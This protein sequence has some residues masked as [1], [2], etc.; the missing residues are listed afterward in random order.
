MVKTAM[1]N[2]AK[3]MPEK[4]RKMKI[5]IKTKTAAIKIMVVLNWKTTSFHLHQRH[6]NNKKMGKKKPEQDLKSHQ[7]RQQKKATATLHPHPKILKAMTNFLDN[8]F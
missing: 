8:F 5:K 6:I 2:H 4:D 3:L 7:I 1:I